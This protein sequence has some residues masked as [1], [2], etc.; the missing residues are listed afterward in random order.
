MTSFSQQ[1]LYDAFWS[2]HGIDFAPKCLHRNVW[3]NSKER[4]FVF[5][6]EENSAVCA[7]HSFILGLNS[8]I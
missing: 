2:L 7:P 6:Q 1:D 3:N 8:S 5:L 4:T